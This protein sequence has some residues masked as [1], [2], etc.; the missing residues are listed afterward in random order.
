MDYAYVKRRKFNWGCPCFS[1]LM[2]N[3]IDSLDTLKQAEIS[4]PQLEKKLGG[5][6]AKLNWIVRK[7]DRLGRKLKILLK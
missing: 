1:T 2:V 6:S 4:E 7:L 5:V 3:R